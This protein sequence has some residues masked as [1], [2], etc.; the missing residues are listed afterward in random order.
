MSEKNETPLPARVVDSEHVTWGEHPRFEGVMLKQL[1]T[2]AD[3]GLASVNMVRL[4]PGREI[5]HHTHP[6][7]VETA[8]ILSG[9][10]YLWLGD[11]EVLFS[12]GEV[13]AVPMNTV[14]GVR[15]PFEQ[16]LEVLAMFTPPLI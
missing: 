4:A 8:F 12:A 5:P 1:L 3:N 7:H 13:V 9:K 6:A 10:A 14:H 2:A 16:D 11:R 15:N